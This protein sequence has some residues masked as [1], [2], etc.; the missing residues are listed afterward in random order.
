[1]A[2]HTD[3]S[4]IRAAHIEG[5]ATRVVDKHRRAG[6]ERPEIIEG[7]RGTSGPADLAP[8]AAML[9]PEDPSGQSSPDTT[10]VAAS[11]CRISVVV[12][13]SIARCRHSGG[14]D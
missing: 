2:R 11:G 9:R 8:V 13:I 12:P 5:T 14:G 1:M 6:Y 4:R 7:L 10:T 3:H